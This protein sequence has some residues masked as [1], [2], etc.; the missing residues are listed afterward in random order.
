MVPRDLVVFIEDEPGASSRLDYAAALAA[1]WQAH[2]ATTFVVDP[3]DLPAHADFAVG[4][5]LTDVLE[6][7]GT[8]AARAVEAAR[9]RFEALLRQHGIAG[10]WRVAKGETREALMLHAR[11]ASLALLGPP[12]RR[13]SSI[14]TLSLSEN[15]VFGSGRPTLLLPDGWPADRISRRIVVGWNAGREATAA[16]AGAMPFLRQADQVHI[17][18]VPEAKAPHLYGDDPGA[19]IACHLARN[20][21]RVDLARRAGA[22]AGGALLAQCREAAADLLVMGAAGRSRIGEFVF[23]GATRTVLGAV[24]VPLLLAS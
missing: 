14:S 18:V 4:K 13:R 5:A 16:I 24:E 21:V 12:A 2:L 1:R 17:V 11:H 22:D 15:V 9:N 6:S 20:G 19:D 7:Y 10:E 8:R 23:G 3:L